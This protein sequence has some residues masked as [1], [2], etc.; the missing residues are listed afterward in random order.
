MANYIDLIKNIGFSDT[1]VP[2]ILTWTPDGG[3]SLT[4]GSSLNMP[5]GRDSIIVTV[6]PSYDNS[7]NSESFSHLPVT[8]MSLLD[9]DLRAST[10]IK[11]SIGNSGFIYL[12]PDQTI[13]TIIGDERKSVEAKYLK[14]GDIIP[15]IYIHECENQTYFKN[16]NGDIWKI[17]RSDS[18]PKKITSAIGKAIAN[19]HI[20]KDMENGG[21]MSGDKY[22]IDD[23][24]I[25][26]VSVSEG[27]LAQKLLPMR[28]VRGGGGY[29]FS[30][31]GSI[32]PHSK[33]LVKISRYT[34]ACVTLD[35][36]QPVPDDDNDD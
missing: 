14:K 19:R 6:N 32:Q 21:Y 8:H 33:A 24:K 12:K 20:K 35:I 25:T 30:N 13:D 10:Y 27:V 34:N 3:L 36:Y 22:Y 26:S 17:S 18:E 31:A 28:L 5:K 23:N 1:M 7:D 29:G 11:I 16:S 15:L 4:E 2:M 9:S